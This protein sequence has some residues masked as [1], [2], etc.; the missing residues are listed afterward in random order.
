MTRFRTTAISEAFTRV[1]HEKR[2]TLEEMAAKLDISRVALGNIMNGSA[3]PRSDLLIRFLEVFDDINPL[4]VLSGEGSMYDKD[5]D[6][7]IVQMAEKM[8]AMKRELEDKRDIILLLKD[9]LDAAK[10]K[11]TN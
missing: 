9:A 5:K 11:T 10:K 8:A 1:R 4:W 6:T 3:N 7:D 2:L